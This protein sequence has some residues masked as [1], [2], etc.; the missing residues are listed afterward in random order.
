M[1]AATADTRSGDEVD[2]DIHGGQ[3]LEDRDVDDPSRA[4]APQDE[5]DLRP[6]IPGRISGGHESPLYQIALNNSRR[7]VKIAVREADEV[8]KREDSP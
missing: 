4:A 6:V 3:G 1:P 5:P 2:R 7:T 8:L